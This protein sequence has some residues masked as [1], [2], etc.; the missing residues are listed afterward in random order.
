M[1]INRK[2][3][4][5]ATWFIE[6]GETKIS[7]FES[8]TFLVTIEQEV[9][10]LE[11]SVHDSK[12]MA[13]VHDFNNSLHQLGSLSLTVMPLPHN[14]MKQL[15]AFAQLHHQVHGRR[16]LVRA[17]DLHHVRLLRQALHYLNLPQNVVV[18]LGVEELAL[19][20]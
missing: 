20:E 9:V 14:P 17:S 12:R 19:W 2:G 5:K 15:F 6:Y 18:V 13:S 3:T 11:V 1:K 4:Q 10:G 16:V 8:G 7:G